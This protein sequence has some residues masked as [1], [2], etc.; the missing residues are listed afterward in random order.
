MNMENKNIEVEIRSFI[1]D[2]QYNNLL[3]KLKVD[4]FFIKEVNEETIYFSGDKDLRLRKNEKEAFIILKEGNIHDDYRKEFEIKFDVSG[5]DDMNNLLKSL[6]HKIEIKWFRKRLE[7]KQDHIK[8]LLDKTKGYGNIIEL[9]K[10]VQSGEEENTHEKLEK[11][12]RKLGIK[13]STKKEFDYAFE[14]YKK[15]WKDLIK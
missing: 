8:I 13:M 6:G 11:R 9:E 12:L 14:Y 10:M 3:L 2:K 4:A 5:F 7:F 15:N 1:D